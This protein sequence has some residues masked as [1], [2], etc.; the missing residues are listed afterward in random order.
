MRITYCWTEPSG[1]LASCIS[2]LASRPGAEVS[3]LT[4]ETDASAPFSGDTLRGARGREL[5]RRERADTG[6][7]ERL[8]A[9]TSPDVLFISGW[10]HRPYTALLESPRLA[11]AKFIMGADTPIRFDWRQRLAPFRI[12]SLL[13]RLDGVVVPGERGYQLM[14]YWGVPGDKITR[15]L[16]G[17]DYRLFSTA[18]AGRFA[19]PE[20]WPRA[21][22][23]AGRYVDVK[24]IGVMVQA[25]RAYRAAVADPWPLH[26][27]GTG[28]LAALLAAEPGV[29]DL[30]FLQPS[31]LAQAFQQAGVFVLPSLH[32]PWGQVIVE[33]AAGGLPAICTQACGAGADLIRDFHN[34]LMVPAGDVGRLA[35]ALLWMHANHARLPAMGADAQVAAAAYGAERWADTQLALAE[36]LMA[37]GRSGR[38]A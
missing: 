23:Y 32:E 19:E 7:V 35:D 36:R 8:V 38:Q 12:G 3:L 27:C 17:I 22:L 31:G 2:E 15:L 16:Y 33:A 28:P 34:G 13:R 30:G 14:R 6:L 4:W 5:S 11:K 18:A 26:T 20:S 25:Y 37:A 1:Y 10:A 24:G 21:F 9:E 29:T